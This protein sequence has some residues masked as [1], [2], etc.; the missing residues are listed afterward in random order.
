MF[1]CLL[2]GWADGRLTLRRCPMSVLNYKS[3]HT[4]GGFLIVIRVGKSDLFT[5]LPLLHCL[6]LSN[7]T[8]PS[9]QTPQP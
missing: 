3:L 7:G 6:A 9:D 1:V 4:Y 8:V 2:F 5:K